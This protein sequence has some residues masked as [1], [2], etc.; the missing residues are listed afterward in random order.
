MICPLA[1]S[2]HRARNETSPESASSVAVVTYNRPPERMGE[3]QPLPG[4]AVFQPTFFSAL[5][6]M[7][8]FEAT[9]TPSPVGPRNCGQSLAAEMLASTKAIVRLRIDIFI[10]TQQDL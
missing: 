2:R 1:A 6:S 10:S 5:H 7:G 3:D 4:I 9:E 8:T